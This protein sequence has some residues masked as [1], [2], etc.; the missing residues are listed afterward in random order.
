MSR[1]GHFQMS[2]STDW[3]WDRRYAVDYRAGV[4]N[5]LRIALIVAPMAVPM[6][7]G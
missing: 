7:S 6:S 2:G 1:A 5:S 3:R 4:G